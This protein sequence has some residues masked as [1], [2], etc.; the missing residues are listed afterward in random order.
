MTDKRASPSE[1]SIKDYK[2]E[3]LIEKKPT[4]ET[5]NDD[6]GPTEEG[7]N[8]PVKEIE[9]EFVITMDRNFETEREDPG[10]PFVHPDARLPKEY[11]S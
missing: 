5:I 1:L 8:Q 10:H 4:N 11:K 9:R 7:T 2:K 3:I 6:K